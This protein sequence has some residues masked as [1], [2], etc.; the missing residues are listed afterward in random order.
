[1]QRV[2]SESRY[3][4]II[5]KRGKIDAE[6]WAEL[7]AELESEAVAARASTDRLRVRA[8]L[9]SVEVDSA[10]VDTE[11]VSR[12]AGV[13]R[14]AD[15]KMDDEASVAAMRAALAILFSHVTYSPGLAAMDAVLP[16]GT[17]LSGEADLVPVLRDDLIPTGNKYPEAGGWAWGTRPVPAGPV[18][19][20]CVRSRHG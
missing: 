8:E 2:D 7:K 11:L 19:T 5:G 14:A 1:M 16:G 15:G 17:Y 13:L 12:L 18:R 10:D 6:T 4:P 3:A 9:L 20:E